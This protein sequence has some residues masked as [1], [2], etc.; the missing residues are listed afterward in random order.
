MRERRAKAEAT[1]VATSIGRGV[2]KSGRLAAASSERSPTTRPIRSSSSPAMP[3]AS[4]TSA[5]SSGS[6]VSRVPRTMV[7]GVRSSWPTSLMKRRCSEKPSWMRPSMRL[8]FCASAATSSRPGGT[9]TRRERSST[10]TSVVA[11]RRSPRGR[12]S[13][14]VTREPTSPAITRVSRAI[15]T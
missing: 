10:V 14:P 4:R 13:R 2:T 7:S 6:V 11:R 1:T 5:G 9:G 8:K 15:T 12:S 3:W